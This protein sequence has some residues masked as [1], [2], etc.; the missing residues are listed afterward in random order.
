MDNVIVAKDGF[1][2]QVNTKW[3][4]IALWIFMVV[5]IGHWVEHIFQGAQIWLLD[6]PRA[7]SLGGLGLLFPWLVSSELMHFGFAVTMFAG[8]MLLRPGFHGRSRGWWNASTIFQGWHLVEHT[9]LFAQVLIGA[10]LFGSPVPSSFLQ[11]F[12]PRA[13]LH[14]L[15]NLI[16]FV[17]MVVAMWLHTRS[18]EH[19]LNGCSCAAEPVA[20]PKIDLSSVTG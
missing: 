14:L 11:P 16:V 18:A 3:H 9:A 5:V 13:E 1:I 8:L 20:A 10:N 12:V 17:P 4:E 19:A 2:N 6:M 15:Y 7:E